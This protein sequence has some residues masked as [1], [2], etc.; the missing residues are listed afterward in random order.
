MKFDNQNLFFYTTHSTLRIRTLLPYVFVQPSNELIKCF[1]LV[2]K[3]EVELKLF[4]LQVAIS[5]SV[6]SDKWHAS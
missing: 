4:Y 2:E 3:F 1:V 5:C 6:S